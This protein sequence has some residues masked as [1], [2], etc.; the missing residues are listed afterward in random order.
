MRFRGAFGSG[1]IFLAVLLANPAQASVEIKDTSVEQFRIQSH[2][3]P[4]EALLQPLFSREDKL[5]VNGGVG[6]ASLSSIQNSWVYSG[7]LMYHFNRR[8]GIEPI[9]YLRSS[10]EISSFIDTEITQK[11]GAARREAL[12]VSVPRQSFIG[13][14]FFSPY[15]AKIHLSSQA[16]SHFDLFIGGGVGATQVEQWDLNGTLRGDQWKATA[17]I[18]TGF[19]MLFQPRFALRFEV[20][21]LIYGQ[22]NFGRKSTGHHVQLGLSLSVFFGSF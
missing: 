4:D 17:L 3:G 8:H 15:H 10:P 19:R 14:Y 20:R 13:S 6:L 5:E 11:I 21:D 7:S 9:Y 12:S 22:D 16:V 18:S 2:Y 1:A